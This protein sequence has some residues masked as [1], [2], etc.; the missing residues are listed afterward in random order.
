MS[1]LRGCWI[2]RIKSII[3]SLLRSCLRNIFFLPDHDAHLKAE[4]G[5]N[6]L[7]H[8]TGDASFDVI[9]SS[10]ALH[11]S[12]RDRSDHEQAINEML[13]VLKPG[14]RIALMDITHMIEGYSSSMQTKGVA[15]EVH[16]TVQS[17]FGFE[18]SVMIGRKDK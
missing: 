16:K 1:P 3:F 17:P 8:F 18:M 9:V 12:G 10:G 6:G 5:L 13:R 2:N 14:G 7:V 15:S 4:R 11:H